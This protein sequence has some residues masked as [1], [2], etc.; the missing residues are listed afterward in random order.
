MKS[1]D[2]EFGNDWNIGV[3]DCSVPT[4][5]SNVDIL[6]QAHQMLPIQ[7]Q[8]WIKNLVKA[9]NQELDE[10]LTIMMNGW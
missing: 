6:I 2:Q 9:E 1:N 7:I 5:E 3:L 4:T 8:K 10:I